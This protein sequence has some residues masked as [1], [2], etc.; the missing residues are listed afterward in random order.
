MKVA[1]TV[2]SKESL[3]AFC[4]P[5]GDAYVRKWASAS[6]L[7]IRSAYIFQ[8]RS[9]RIGQGFFPQLIILYNMHRCRLSD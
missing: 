1:K 2:Y 3:A 9:D 5:G 6:P 8:M 7:R 4:I